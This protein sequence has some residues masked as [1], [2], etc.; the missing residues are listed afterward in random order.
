MPSPQQRNAY[1]LSVRYDDSLPPL[2]EFSSLPLPKFSSLPLP[3]F[4]STPLPKFSSL[5]LPKFSSLPMPKFSSPPL[6]KF[7]TYTANPVFVDAV[8][9]AEK[10]VCVLSVV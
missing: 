10:R 9:A 7:S 4:S 8:T 1:A 2:P 3:K 6:P 5:P